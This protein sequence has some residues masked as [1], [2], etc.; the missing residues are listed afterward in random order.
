MG[1][2]IIHLAGRVPRSPPCQQGLPCLPVCR[3]SPVPC[4]LPTHQP[5][6]PTDQTG[7]DH[8]HG[9]HGVSVKFE[10]DPNFDGPSTAHVTSKGTYVYGCVWVVGCKGRGFDYGGAVI[11]SYPSRYASSHTRHATGG[12]G[13]H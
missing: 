13:H 9:G 6:N 1:S 4:P 8:G 12:H 3:S 7:D 11:K 10:D 2:T 5:T